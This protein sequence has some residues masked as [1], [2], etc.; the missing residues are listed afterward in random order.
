M[1]KNILILGHSYIPPFVD[2]NNQYAAL[3]DQHHVTVVYL[4]GAPDEAIRDKHLNQDVIF[5]N[6]SKKSIKGLKLNAI[7]KILQLC[8]KM[9]FD[10]VICHRYKPAYIMLWVSLFCKIS[11]I[12]FVM[13]ELRTMRHY[14]RKLLVA[15]LARK[16]MFFVG[17]SN[18]VRDDIRHDIW[19]VPSSRILTFY[20]MINVNHMEQIYLTREVARQQLNLPQD[21][22]I[23]GHLGRLVKNKDQ[24]TLIHAF[25]LV[26]Q[27]YQNVKL[28]IM[29][30]GELET[31]LKSQVDAD[32][33]REDVLFPGFIPDG[34]CLIKAF[35]VYISSSTQEAFGR[36]LL[37]AMAAKVPII[38]THVH[39]VPEVLG[40][41]ATLI[42]AGSAEILAEQMMRYY[43][44][45]PVERHVWGEKAYERVTRFFSFAQLELR[46]QHLLN[47]Y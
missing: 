10:I 41:A 31:D 40:D 38:A 21:A 4:T 30:A 2:V 26:K 32:G 7:K 39:G 45:P 9:K 5:L 37:E 20:N 22:F 33:L 36:V 3:F 13:H 35:D 16:N 14:S 18:A 19:R 17:V 27:H 25:K 28:V 24:K 15:L 43:V 11:S 12:F 1:K 34:A 29:G 42:E 47:H 46:F 6:L 44:M 23:F 8:Y